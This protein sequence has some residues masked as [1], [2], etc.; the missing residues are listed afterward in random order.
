MGYQCICRPPT[1]MTAKYGFSSY[2]KRILN[3]YILG[4]HCGNSGHT[5]N[6]R[7]TE[8]NVATSRKFTVVSVMSPHERNAYIACNFRKRLFSVIVFPNIAVELSVFHSSL[9]ALLRPHKATNSQ[10]SPLHNHPQA[11][12]ILTY[13][14]A[15]FR[16]ATRHNPQV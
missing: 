10:L 13:L 14:Q 11:Q 16:P 9:S 4:P 1:L 3:S 5:E 15:P 8:E 6:S 2:L 12:I 7:H